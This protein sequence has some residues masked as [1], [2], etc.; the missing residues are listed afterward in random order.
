MEELNTMAQYLYLQKQND[1]FCRLG[2]TRSWKYKYDE[3]NDL[4]LTN[5]MNTFK[6]KFILN[7]YVKIEFFGDEDDRRC[8]MFGMMPPKDHIKNFLFYH[9]FYKKSILSGG[10]IKWKAEAFRVHKYFKFVP[11][12]YYSKNRN[13]CLIYGRNPINGKLISKVS[14]GES[15]DIEELKEF[16]EHL[17]KELNIYELLNIKD[18]FSNIPHDCSNLS[19]HD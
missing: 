11:T 14:I 13:F 12:I 7:S 6:K 15:N 19:Y 2:S 1:D 16:F 10:E 8:R 3:N 17:Y 18:K 4:V 5:G 9:G